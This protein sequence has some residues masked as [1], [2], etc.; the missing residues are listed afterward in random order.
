MDF[1]VKTFETL[2]SMALTALPV[3]V[4]VLT[5]RW[6][7]KKVPKKYTYLLWLV[8]A[9]RLIC[10]MTI[11]T[12][13]SIIPQ[14][15]PEQ[16]A[17]EIGIADVLD[18]Y[19]DDTMMVF[20][21]GPYSEV[22]EEA[23][24]AGRE[25]YY[26]GEPGAYYVVTAP[27]G[28]SPPTT[29]ADKL[30]PVASVLWGLGVIVAIGYITLG[31]FRL[32]KQV[33][34]A[35]RREENTWECDGIPT[36]FVMGLLRPR[37]YIPFH[38]SDEEQ[39]YVLAHEQYH[40][41]H[42]DHW[43]KVLA[44]G[45]LAVYWWNPVVWLCWVLFCRDMEMRCD[46][47]V[48]AQLGEDV[49]RD[50]SLSLVSFALDRRF[51][52]ALAF[53]EHDAEK[54]VKNVLK[55]KKA[56]PITVAIGIIV[57]IVV[58]VV[59][60]TN[61][62]SASW[63]RVERKPAETGGV[64]FI[65]NLEEPVQAWALYEDI[66][67]NGELISSSP[68]IMDQF[69]DNGGA[70]GRKSTVSLL[71]HPE[72]S[73]DGGFGDSLKCVFDGA[74]GFFWSLDLPKDHYSGMGQAFM[75]AYRTYG[76][77]IHKKHKLDSNDEQ[78]LATVVLST[79]ENGGT[80]LF[81][82][83]EGGVYAANDTVVQYRL[84]TAAGGIETFEDISLN[85]A[86][87]I[88][89][90]WADGDRW[91]LMAALLQADLW[92]GPVSLAAH[93]TTTANF[94]VTVV[95]E[96]TP[97]DAEALD[98]AMAR[99]AMVLLKLL[100]AE[101]N[102]VQW[103]YLGENGMENRTLHVNEASGITMLSSDSGIYQPIQKA[104][105]LDRFIRFLNL[106]PKAFLHY[107]RTEDALSLERVKELAAV[108]FAPEDI[109]NIELAVLE[110]WDGQRF[111]PL[112]GEGYEA[113]ETMLRTAKKMNTVPDCSFHSA[114][115][116]HRADGIVGRIMVAEDTCG[117]FLSN[118]EFYTFGADNAEFY[119][120]F[121]VRGEELPAYADSAE[122]LRE[123]FTGILGY[124]GYL[125]RVSVGGPFEQRI[126][127]AVSGGGAWPIA[128]SFGFGEAQD[129]SVDL[130]GDGVKELVT[131]VQY[132]GDGHE[133][134]YVYRRVG[135]GPAGI[136]RGVLDLSDLPNHDNWGVNSTSAAYDPETNEFRI[137]YTQ[138]N[139][140]EYGEVVFRGLERFEFSTF[141][142]LT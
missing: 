89:D 58:V 96:E 55:W 71:I 65:W 141:E 50:Y 81:S 118:E 142:R 33:S 119:E 10:P 5:A 88:Y 84:V 4:V 25:P 97:Q 130:D 75:D 108:W 115:Y 125:Q 52:A 18:Y 112:T 79:K 17:E 45:I 67:E 127:Y 43:A 1:L 91:S 8:V 20:S 109:H 86:Q 73:K 48:L 42:L 107:A 78:V 138:K 92:D 62:P 69:T 7:L 126:Y 64:Q 121:G 123:A 131:N 105:D 34:T 13:F 51:P 68:R 47:A 35:V 57:V 103:S 14:N 120:V 93:V 15:L 39:T 31:A 12:V 80:T 2:L 104:E 6:L 135:D 100:P 24:E 98:V 60:G 94:D 46:E 134:V 23:V 133:T 9:F 29:R 99:R 113:L 59:C 102:R 3:M 114:L 76:A 77:R 37:I 11:D 129:Y 41:Q 117:L 128:E 22:Y 66:Y 122:S 82:A 27:D 139:T 140:E 63:V 74:G 101:I 95:F 26:A 83:D 116:L 49:K 72:Y 54:R 87:T 28:I 32:K 111:S 19:V 106:D 61:A 56:T 90:L 40:L 110:W 53:G 132:G 70:T 16:I 30:L 137:R 38:L 124:D 36:P 21:T 136:W 85:L 44:L